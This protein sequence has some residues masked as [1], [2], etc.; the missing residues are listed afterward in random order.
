MKK[1]L[2][3][4]VLL[5]LTLPVLPQKA[6]SLIRKAMLFYQNEEFDMAIP[7]FQ[8]IIKKQP[9][10]YRAYKDLG[11]CYVKTRQIEKAVSS[12]KE[13]LTI[14]PD[15]DQAVY[16][17]G[18]AYD[19]SD[20]TDSA[21]YWFRIYTGMKPDDPSG[22]IRMSVIYMDLP[23][24]VDSSV[25]YAQK[26]LN[27]EPSNQSAY[28]T[29]AMAYM[30]AEKY[31]QSVDAAV[32]GLSYDSTNY[33]LY[34]PWGLSLFFQH[35]Y[36]LAYQVFS[37]GVKYETQGTDLVR[38]RAISL[39]MKNTPVE[40]YRFNHEG[41]PRFQT[42]T[43]HNMDK[44]DQRIRDPLDRY[45]YP[46]LRE[47]FRDAPL[48]MGLDDFFMYYYGFASSDHYSPYSMSSD[49]L[50]HYLGAG[51]YKQYINRA[52]I[53]LSADPTQFPVYNTLSMVYK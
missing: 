22:Y 1:V 41:Q 23:G 30:Q 10:N 39:I 50:D 28:Y 45:Y 43:V 52:E 24:T 25:H 18:N 38:Y 35:N 12:Y 11:E 8:E 48:S 19:I 37:K 15:Y 27:L 49:S 5:L 14:K 7:V 16:G 36:G 6:D 13:A 32:K 51:R 29:L 42:F 3:F 33:L 21:L 20:R 46:T 2:L 4:P 40:T 47:K 44:L 9:V 17:L 34:Y 26:A 31:N 53:F